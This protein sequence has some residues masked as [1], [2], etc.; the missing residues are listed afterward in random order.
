[1]PSPCANE[2]ELQALL[3]DQLPSDEQARWETHLAECDACRAAFEA[4]AG[5]TDEAW[6][7]RA[8]AAARETSPRLEQ[9]MQELKA[10][11]TVRITPRAV[12]TLLAS[13]RAFQRFGDYEILGELGRGGMGVVFKARQLSLKRTVA[14]K[15]ILSGQLASAP[16]VRRF[17]AEAEA[18]A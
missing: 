9:V 3:K 7:P 10:A 14:L 6:L 4:L 5:G 12:D 16:E 17:R 2:A 8:A 18:A 13:G 1:M 15:L 11:E